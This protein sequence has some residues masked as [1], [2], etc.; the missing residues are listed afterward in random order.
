MLTSFQIAFL[1]SV[2]GIT[3]F[4]PISSSGHLALV[5]MVTGWADQGLTLDIAVHVGTLGAVIAYFR[6]DSWTAVKGLLRLFDGSPSPDARLAANLIVATL[7]II[8]AGAAVMYFDLS[9][10]WRNAE[11]IG[12]SMLGFGILLYA[13]DRLG[14]TTRH[15]EHMGTGAALMIGVAQV[16]AL[17]PGASRAG[18]TITAARMLGFE[19]DESARFSMLLSIPTI[20][21]AGLVGVHG[22]AASRDAALGVDAVIAAVCALAA[23][24]LAIPLLMAWLRRR[25]FTP[26]VIY[27]VAAGATVLYW[28]YF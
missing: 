7:P 5:P 15:V 14:M 4:L 3:E 10:L 25:T 20:L 19:R 12:W 27:R 9:G 17:I 21:A 22:I 18:V 11:V 2:Q 6:R 24:L 16:A 8:G 26:F 28:T 1:A 23:A 13:A